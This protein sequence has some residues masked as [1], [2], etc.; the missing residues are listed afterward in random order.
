GPTGSQRIDTLVRD[1]V[2]HSAGEE[3]IRQGREVGQAMLRLRKFMFD[4]VYLGPEARREQ[5]RV[6]RTMRGLFQHYLEHPDEVPGRDPEASL[7]QRVT[8]YIAGMTD[9]FCIAKFTELTV[10]EESRF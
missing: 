3:E 5:G 6:Q 7:Q 10:P 8:D 1:I 2:A 4:R 9:R